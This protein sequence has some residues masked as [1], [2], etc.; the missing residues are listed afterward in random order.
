MLESNLLPGT[1]PIKARTELR[2]GISVTDPCIGWEETKSLLQQ[3][4]K[5]VREVRHKPLRRLN[6][7]SFGNAKLS[8]SYGS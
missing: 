5:V 3:A 1:Q 8:H 7:E 6:I 4:A 2:Y